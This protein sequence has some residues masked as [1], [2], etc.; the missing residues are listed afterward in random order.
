MEM[1]LANGEAGELGVIVCDVNGLKRINDTLGHQAG[2]AY[3]RSA[4]DLLC[5]F[6]K[7]SPV[8]RIGGDEFV[9]FLQGRDYE[10]RGELLRGINAQIEENLGSGKV[11]A[12]LGMVEFESW[13]KA[14]S[15][16]EIAQGAEQLAAEAR[17]LAPG[18][19][20][21]MYFSYGSYMLGTAWGFEG[22]QQSNFRPASAWIG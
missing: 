4:C 16:E 2:D 5:E 14:L 6:F 7:H 22:F 9:V 11:V 17:V 20:V 1:Q 3:I 18:Y 8:F 12:S 10:A 21:T 15:A 13:W 19:T